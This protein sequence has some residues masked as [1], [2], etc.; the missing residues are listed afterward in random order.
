[1]GVPDDRAFE[2][3]SV[4]TALMPARKKKEPVVI[5]FNDPA[6]TGGKWLQPLRDAA[7]KIRRAVLKQARKPKT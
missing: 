4:H 7:E 3:P 1:M 6:L 2:I 5:D